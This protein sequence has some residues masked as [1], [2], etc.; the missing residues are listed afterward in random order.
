M[1]FHKI[2]TTT[3]VAALLASTAANAQMF[4]DDYGT[5]MDYDTFNTG[6]GET[7]YYDAWD[8]NDDAMLDE[9][10]FATGVYADWDQDGDLEITEEEYTMGTERWFGEDYD[11]AFTDWDADESGYL[12]QSEFGDAWDNEYYTE[13]DTDQDTL[14]SQDEYTTGLYDS[15]D[16]DENQVITVEEEGWFEGWFDGDDVEAEIQEVGDVL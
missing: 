4:G 15:A 7:G 5:D 12:D 6:F 11:T 8:M 13:W 9:N 3:A 14:L 16:Y 2:F 1:R 10:E